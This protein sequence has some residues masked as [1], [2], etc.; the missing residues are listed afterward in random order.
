MTTA[1]AGDQRRAE[2]NASKHKS[3]QRVAKRRADEN[4]EDA[5]TENQ[6]ATKAPAKTLAKT[7]IKAPAKKTGK[8]PVRTTRSATAKAMVPSIVTRSR[9]EG[10][11]KLETPSMS[12]PPGS[13]QASGDIKGPN[14][15]IIPGQE[16]RF[17]F[18]SVDR[19]EAIFQDPSRT[20]TSVSS[21]RT[22][23]RTLVTKESGILAALAQQTRDRRYTMEHLV[24]RLEEELKRM[25]HAGNISSD[26][27]RAESDVEM[28]I[29]G[30][31][32]LNTL[33][34]GV[35]TGEIGDNTQSQEAG[36]SGT[37]HD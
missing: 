11:Q 4:R 35:G 18:E 33:L 10:F 28:V 15:P 37:K 20:V 5:E 1:D 31:G 27:V 16:H 9:S 8:T 23:L 19:Y 6:I 25:N 29:T 17:F 2:Q 30:V 32:E 14:A 21:A 36:P 7:S 13:G 34:G 26:R 24:H 12:L 3:L 22:E